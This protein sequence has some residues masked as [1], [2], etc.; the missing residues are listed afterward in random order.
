MNS[1]SRAALLTSAGMVL[2]S[3]WNIPEQVKMIPDATKFHEIIRNSLGLLGIN[4]F[5]QGTVIGAAI[6]FAVLFDR[7]RNFRRSE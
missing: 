6:L 2:P 4:P 7:I 1:T 5:W 3:A